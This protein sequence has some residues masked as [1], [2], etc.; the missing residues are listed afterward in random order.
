MDNFVFGQHSDSTSVSGPPLRGKGR[1]SG[2]LWIT[3]WIT[4]D[5]FDFIP[6]LCMCM[7]CAR[8]SYPPGRAGFPQV[9]NKLSTG[10]S[11]VVTPPV[12]G[13][14]R[15]VRCPWAVGRLRRAACRPCSTR[16][17]AFGAGGEGVL[18]FQRAAH[19]SRPPLCPPREFGRPGAAQ[20]ARRPTVPSPGMSVWLYYVVGHK[21]HCPLSKAAGSGS[22]VRR[23]GRRA[24]VPE[25]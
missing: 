21:Q 12:R 20:T 6:K 2:P 10:V 8:R 14:L 22:G 1:G 7:G 11:A 17:R 19:V 24:R 3:L 5:N 16:G 15:P 9:V 13:G 4:V 23:A 18:G 25:E